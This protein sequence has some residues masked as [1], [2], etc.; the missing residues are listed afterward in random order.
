MNWKGM[1]LTLLAFMIASCVHAPKVAPLSEADLRADIAYLSAPDMMGREPG[2]VAET[3]VADFLINRFGKAGLSPAFATN[4]QT[5]RAGW[6]QPVNLQKRAPIGHEVRYSKGKAPL[7]VPQGQLIF[8]GTQ[9]IVE[10]K[11]APIYFIGRGDTADIGGQNLSGAVVLVQAAA[12]T[13][14]RAARETKLS[15]QGVLGVVEI[16]RGRAAFAALSSPLQRTHFFEPVIDNAVVPNRTAF[17][18]VMAEERAV[19]L[20]SLL[21]KDWD[22]LML[23]SSLPGYAGEFLGATM[24]ISLQT[25]IETVQSNNIGGV[26]KGKR[27]SAGAVLFI[28]HW[29]HLGQCAPRIGVAN[30]VCPG[31]IDNA[32]GIAALLQIADALSAERHDRDIYFIATTGEEHGFAGAK[33]LYNA[34]PVHPDKVQA[35]F[36]LDMLAIAPAGTPVAIVGAQGDRMDAMIVKVM[37]ELGHVV[38]NNELSDSFRDRQDGWVFLQAGLPARMVNSSYGDEA[39]LTA[40]LNSAYHSPA[41]YYSA[42]IELGGA[43]QDIRLHIALGRAFANVKRYPPVPSVAG[44]ASASPQLN[45]K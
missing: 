3:P 31:A 23:R 10:A 44:D 22:K 33:A 43:I 13:R 14:E 17:I 40:F 2:G 37:G 1:C 4:E 30:I 35:I 21:G 16:V 15:A 36:N 29:D 39:A 6:A 20:V 32:S 45:L 25:R 7:A 9:E 18:G 19:A 11:A 42:A 34:M 5:T 26:I 28:A 24:A 8:V 38:A 41:D 12:T 27:P